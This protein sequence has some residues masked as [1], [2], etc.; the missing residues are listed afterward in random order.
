MIGQTAGRGMLGILRIEIKHVNRKTCVHQISKIS[1]M[2]QV[3]LCV[4]TSV[5]GCV[6]A[7]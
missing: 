1:P 5:H 2:K 4:V 6:V 3:R 7:D